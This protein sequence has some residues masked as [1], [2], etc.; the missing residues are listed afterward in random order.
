MKHRQVN[1]TNT[2]KFPCASRLWLEQQWQ[3]N[4][5]VV[6]AEI[7][8]WLQHRAE[9]SYTQ[10]APQA[11]SAGSWHSPWK[12]LPQEK[13]VK[14]ITVFKAK[15]LTLSQAKGTFRNPQQGDHR[16]RPANWLKLQPTPKCESDADKFF[17][18]LIGDSKHLR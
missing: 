2:A 15:Q 17:L 13:A 10:A 5:S 6:L 12:C 8:N 4:I 3:E 9:W 7:Q 18:C 16:I 11:V 1:I 14:G